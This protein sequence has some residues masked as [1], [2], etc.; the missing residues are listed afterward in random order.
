MA[1]PVGDG[2]DERLVAPGQLEQPVGELAVG[3]LVAGADVV[4]LADRALLEHEVR[5]AVV[6]LDVDPVADVA[7]VAVERH[8]L[9]V[10][11]VG[12]EQRDDLLGELVRPEVV[13]S[14]G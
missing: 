14:T 4:D 8:L 9:A 12:G 1:E 11:Q 13:A 5:G 7:A 6:V 10:E 3:D 2:L